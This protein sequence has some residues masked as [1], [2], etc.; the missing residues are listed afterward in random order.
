MRGGGEGRQEQR[1]E[2]EGRVWEEE[3]EVTGRGGKKGGDSEGG[4]VEEEE[5]DEVKEGKLRCV[6]SESAWLPAGSL[7]DWVRKR[8]GEKSEAGR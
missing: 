2:T 6:E 3:G 7:P 5:E 1:A 4:E 8:T